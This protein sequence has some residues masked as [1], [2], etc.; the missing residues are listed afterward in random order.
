MTTASASPSRTSSVATRIDGVLLLA[1][2]QRGVLVH[3]DDRSG[4][5]D[6]DVVGKLAGDASDRVGVADEDQL[7]VGVGAGVV[8]DSRDDLGR[9]VVAAHRVERDADH[10]ISARLSSL[11]VLTGFGGT[12]RRPW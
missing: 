5:D 8:D 1:Q 4:V 11:P 12:A 7:D 2:G 3:A 9:A 10:R 6:A